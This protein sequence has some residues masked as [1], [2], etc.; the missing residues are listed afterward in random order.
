[1]NIK[2]QYKNKGKTLSRSFKVK[3]QDEADKKLDDIK[4][5]LE[6]LKYDEKAIDSLKL[7]KESKKEFLE[8]EFDTY[9]KW[10]SA[11][12]KLDS[13]VKF[14]GDE[15]I[16]VA[17]SKKGAWNTAEWDGETGIIITVIKESDIESEAKSL[18]KETKEFLEEAKVSTVVN[19]LKK[20]GIKFETDEP[21]YKVF[22]VGDYTFSISGDDFAMFDMRKDRESF[23]QRN[24]SVSQFIDDIKG[25]LEKNK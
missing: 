16:N 5:S 21:K 12:K 24:P 23:Y 22:T 8:K 15:D 13:A 4:K 18:I 11:V 1:M 20:L 9:S 7:I 17:I 2:I 10:K 6:K 19:K 3:D 14:D 25:E